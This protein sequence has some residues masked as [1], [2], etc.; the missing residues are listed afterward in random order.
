MLLGGEMSGWFCSCPAVF[1][2]PP[3]TTLLFE[4]SAAAAAAALAAALAAVTTAISANV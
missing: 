4:L 3:L 2:A 1:V